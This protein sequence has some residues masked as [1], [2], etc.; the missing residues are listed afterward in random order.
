MNPLKRKRLLVI[1]AVAG[2]S[3]LIILPE[4]GSFPDFK[5]TQ[6]A[7]SYI[8]MAEGHPQ[9]VLLHH[10]RRML[11]PWVVGQLRW[12]AG[13]D[14]AFLIVGILS[15][16]VFLWVVTDRLFREQNYPL[17]ACAGFIFLP[18]LFILFDDL[19]IQTLFFWP[20][21]PS[22]G[23]RSCKNAIGSGSCFFSP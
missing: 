2:M 23:W 5:Y 15:L 6:D 9:D 19:Y 11:H 14:P 16:F 12:I 18:Y 13:T 10:A 17:T 8:R 21:R 20:C 4:I 7:K 1:L 22:S 3:L